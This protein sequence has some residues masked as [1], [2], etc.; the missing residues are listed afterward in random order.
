MT[1]PHTLL[2][3]PQ[4]DEDAGN[5]KEMQHTALVELHYFMAAV[6]SIPYDS[7]PSP[8]RQRADFV[9]VHDFC[10]LRSLRLHVVCH[11]KQ[12]SL[13]CKGKV[14]YGIRLT[15]RLLQALVQACLL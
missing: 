7:E 1:I 5:H 11:H 10:L 14:R 6:S 13:Q 15:L 8:G 3:P 9:V 4:V 2:R 12:R